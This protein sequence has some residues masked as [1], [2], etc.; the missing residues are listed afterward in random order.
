VVA[1]DT[2]NAHP[3]GRHEADAPPPIAEAR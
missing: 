1:S 2:R 3:A